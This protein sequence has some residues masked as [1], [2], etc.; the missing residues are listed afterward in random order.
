MKPLDQSGRCVPCAATSAR[1]IPRRA[2]LL[3]PLGLLQWPPA[4]LAQRVYRIGLLGG[5]S[6]TSLQSA[7]I[8]GGL[9][10][11]L[12][13]LGYVE[14]KN[15]TVEE[16]WYEDQLERLPALADELV[17]L[18]PDVLVVG[19]QPAPEAA[20][21]A[22]A[23]IPIVMMFHTDP[24]G[25]GLVGSLAKPGGNVTGMTLNMLEFRGRQLQLLKEA[26]PHLARV[27]VLWN[28][29]TNVGR[30]EMSALQGA[31]RALKVEL[32]FA[33][34]RVASEFAD[35]FAAAS[36]RPANAVL[37]LGGSS[38]YF[39][40]RAHIAELAGMNRLPVIYGAKEFVEAGGLMSYGVDF[41]DTARRAAR[42]VDRIL[43]GTSPSD[44]PVEQP[45][46][47]ELTVNLKSAKAL[48][49]IIPASMLVR[50]DRV[51]E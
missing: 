41:R 6:R 18:R 31:A 48:G 7:H 28:P 12:R 5:T 19:T 42:L 34:V 27:T 9:F 30:Y 45:L 35:A 49:L 2:W 50:A 20:K 29:T 46:Q 4:A 39:S 32:S 43:K 14:G 16:R 36:R 8:W 40:Q 22:T 21:R 44:L 1:T 3:A 15:L 38:L 26:V 17:K 23:A 51:I 37:L 33:E 13:A 24:I 47:Y 25:S 10:D 11:G